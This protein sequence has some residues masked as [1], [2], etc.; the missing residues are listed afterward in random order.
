MNAFSRFHSIISRWTC[1]A[2]LISMSSMALPAR[3]QELIGLY[4][5]WNDDP[6]TTMTV[7]WVDIYRESGNSVWYRLRGDDEWTE[8]EAEQSDVGPTTMQLRQVSL[9]DLEPGKTYEFGIRSKPRESG[10]RWRFRTLPKELDEPMRFVTG[11]DMMH[12]RAKVD[13]MNKQM[14]ELDPEFALLGGDLAYADGVKGMRWID[15]LES[16]KNYSVGEQRRLI[17]MVLVIGNHEVRGHYGGKIPD[18]APYFYSLFSLPEDRSYYALDAGEYLSLIALDSGHTQAIDGD[19]AE[20]LE[21][22]LAERKEQKFVFTCY[23]FPAYGTTKGPSGGTP[24]DNPIA[25][26]IQNN[27]VPHFDRY[28][29]SAAFENDHHNF[30]RSHRLR[31][32]ER[33]DETGILYLGDGAWGVRTREVPDDAWWLAKAEPRNHLWHVE[34]RPDGSMKFEAIDVEGEVFDSVE[35]DEPRPAPVE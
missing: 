16:W 22:A 32:H 25:K 7:N 31:G 11:G 8:V 21:E 23:H 17:P 10:D 18:D 30:K 13:A 26:L 29:I 1:I 28:G 5:T 19:Q 4:L 9:K 33:D 35:V 15:W 3:A 6:T 12:T 34:I 14:Q 24:L 2:V 20:W 27:W